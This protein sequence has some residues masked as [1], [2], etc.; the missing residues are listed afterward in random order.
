[1]VIRRGGK[2][3]DSVHRWKTWR[4]RFTRGLFILPCKYWRKGWPQPLAGDANCLEAKRNVDTLPGRA[5]GHRD[6]TRREVVGKRWLH[7]FLI[8]R[9]RERIS[10]AQRRSMI[11]WDAV[12]DGRAAAFHSNVLM[13]N[14]NCTDFYETAACS[15]SVW[16]AI[17][18]TFSRNALSTRF[19]ADEGG[20]GC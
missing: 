19:L 17:I 15:C 13:E 12:D 18:V 20:F 5:R 3:R 2:G 4:K 7:C 9:C 11:D 8:P 6:W 16:L 14:M 1:M 10:L